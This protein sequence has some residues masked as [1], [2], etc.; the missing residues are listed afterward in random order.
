MLAICVQLSLGENKVTGFVYGSFVSYVCNS[1]Y[2]FPD[3]RKRVKLECAKNGRWSTDPGCVIRPLR[4]QL[5]KK[6]T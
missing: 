2:Q 5:R 6:E 3:G 4:H 1:S